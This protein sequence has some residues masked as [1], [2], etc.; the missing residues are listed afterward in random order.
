ML[1]NLTSEN[2]KDSINKSFYFPMGEFHLQL[3]DNQDTTC[4]ILYQHPRDIMQLALAVNAA[5]HMDKYIHVIIPYLPYARQDRICNINEPNSSEVFCE[6][7]NGLPINEITIFDP[8]SLS[9]YSRLL[10]NLN[11]IEQH[12]LAINVINSDTTIDYIIA[13][14]KGSV[15]KAKKLSDLSGLPLVIC[16]KVRD[17]NTG[18][19]SGFEI[20]EGKENNHGLMVDDIGDGCGTMVGLRQLFTNEVTL[21][22]THGGFTKGMGPLSCFES[23]W[24]TNSLCHGDQLF[25]DAKFIK[26]KFHEID[27]WSQFTL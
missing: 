22:V 5:Y 19:L 11:I 8:H 1:I 14:D 10:T 24:T 16:N 17:S 21:Y 25:E 23:I 3:K 9:S 4:T 20:I 27:I 15:E 26:K 13:P 6:F 18:K 7:L 12:T 2:I